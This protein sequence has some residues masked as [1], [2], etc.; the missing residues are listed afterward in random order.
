MGQRWSVRQYQPGD[1]SQILELQKVVHPS[2]QYHRE[3]WTSRAHWLRWRQWVQQA[4][5]VRPARILLAED[6]T[7]IVGHH[8]LIFMLLKVG[9]QIVRACQPTGRMTHPEYR[10]QGIA[11]KFQGQLLDETER[12]GVYITIGFPNKAAHAVDMKTGYVFDIATTRIVFRPLNWGNAIRLRIGTRVLARFGAIVG[13]ILYGVF[14]RAKG[15]PVVEGLTISQVPSFD[16]RVNEFWA[17]VS[18]QYEIMVVR[19]REYLNWR[20]VAVPDIDYSIYIAEK[21][22]EICGYLVLRFMQREHAKLGVICDIVTQSPQISQC[23][24][25]RAVEHCEREKADVVYGNMIADGTLIKSFRNNGFVP[26]LKSERFVV[27][28]RSPHVCGKFLRDSRNWFVQIG[29]SY[30]V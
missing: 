3:Q 16:E 7:K 2:R 20:Y 8:S 29:D 25:S 28:S 26:F 23:L 27:Y 4:N 17:R 14:Y 6:D 1:E 13:R 11:L 10:R 12:E 15:V 21:G 9:D 24:I 19:N 18:R 22:G 30:H 5:P